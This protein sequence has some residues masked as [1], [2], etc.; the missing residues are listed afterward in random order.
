MHVEEETGLG[1]GFREVSE[2]DGNEIA[3]NC[4]W[5]CGVRRVVEMSEAGRVPNRWILKPECTR[6]RNV[7]LF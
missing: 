3:G 4:C 2:R 1:F 5:V 7:Y 6:K